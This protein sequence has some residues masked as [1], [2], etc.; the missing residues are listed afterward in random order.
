MGEM[1]DRLKRRPQRKAM[2]LLL[3]P[4]IDISMVGLHLSAQAAAIIRLRMSENQPSPHT[5]IPGLG[6]P[7]CNDCASAV[8]VVQK[9]QNA[10]GRNRRAGRMAEIGCP[11][12]W[13]RGGGVGIQ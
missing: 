4:N 2:P 6:L 9:L 13:G 11:I 12:F 1:S 10:V 7:A 8:L 3:A 5:S